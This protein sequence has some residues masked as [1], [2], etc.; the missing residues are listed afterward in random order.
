MACLQFLVARRKMEIAQ[1]RACKDTK[2]VDHPCGGRAGT[3]DRNP[4][5]AGSLLF[6]LRAAS[7]VFGICVYCFPKPQDRT[8]QVSIC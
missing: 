1:G 8:Q 5:G 7:F 4:E 3:S 6:L 2:E